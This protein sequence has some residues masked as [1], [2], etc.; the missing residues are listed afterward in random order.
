M[1]H[2]LLEAPAEDIA[3]MAQAHIVDWLVFEKDTRAASWFEKKWTGE[4]GNYTNASA[5]Y[6]ATTNQRDVS[7]TGNTPSGIRWDR[8]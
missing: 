1:A 2:E 3:R 6:V 5:G 4:H 7:P 8:W